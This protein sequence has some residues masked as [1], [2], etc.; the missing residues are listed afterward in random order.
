MIRRVRNADRRALVSTVVLTIVAAVLA[1]VTLTAQGI[2]PQRA[3][4]N[5]GGV[6]VTRADSGTLARFIPLVQQLNSESQPADLPDFDVIQNGK[7]V[8]VLDPQTGSLALVDPRTGGVSAPVALA[9]PVSVALGGA[10]ESPVLAFLLRST[11]ALFVLEPGSLSAFKPEEAQ[12][13]ATVDSEAAVAV[14]DSGLVTVLNPTTRTLVSFAAGSSEG[15][16]AQP[17]PAD[18]VTDG[19]VA[20]AMVGDRPVVLDS[21]GKLWAGGA[22]VD[23]ARE[24]GSQLV[25]QKSGPTASTAIVAGTRGLFEVGLD[26]G[27]VSPLGGSVQAV[28][29]VGAVAAPVRLPGGC[30]YG[31]FV[32]ADYPRQARVCSGGDQVRELRDSQGQFLPSDRV[33]TLTYRVNFGLAVLNDTSNGALWDADADQL[34]QIVWTQDPKE[35]GEPS[36]APTTFVETPA[37]CSTDPTSPQAKDD[38][39]GARAGLPVVIDVLRNDQDADCDVMA[40]KGTPQQ[41]SGPDAKV[42]LVGDGRL[43]QITPPQGAT[44]TLEFTYVVSDPRGD[45]DTGRISV[46]V[47]S[48][49]LPP[50]Q[51]EGATSSTVVVSGKSVSYAVLGDWEDPDG[52]P[53]QLTGAFAPNNEGVVRFQPDGLVT[54][55]DGGDNVG[56]VSLVVIVSDG[57]VDVEG[58]L[59]VDVRSPEDLDPKARPDYATGSVGDIVKID[60]LTN[61]SDP[62]GDALRLVDVKPQF[63]GAQD[64]S[65]DRDAGVLALTATAPGDFGFSYQLAAGRGSATGYARIRIEK[66]AGNRPPAAM[67]DLTGAPLNGDVTVD[68]LRNDVDPD[69]DVLAVT[70]VES[71]DPAV[72]ARIDKGATVRI[73]LLS[74]ITAPVRV[75][76]SVTDGQEQVDSYITVFLNSAGMTQKPLARADE[77]VVRAGSMTTIPVLANDVAGDGGA[78]TLGRDLVTPAALGVAAVN[79]SSVRYVAPTTGGRD[80]FDYRLVAASDPTLRAVGSV[81]VIVLDPGTTNSPPRPQQIEA[82]VVAGK[83]VSIAVPLD[84]IDPEGD[85]VFLDSVTPSALLG[86]IPE[87]DRASQRITYQAGTATGTDRFTYRVCD[88]ATPQ[89]CA[90]GVV[91]VGVYTRASNEA[92]EAGPDTV[93]MRPGKTLAVDVLANDSDPDGDEFGFVKSDPLTLSTSSTVTARLD[94]TGKLLLIEASSG[95]GT[96]SITY[97]IT[98]GRNVSSGLVSVRVS[99]SAPQFAPVAA[100]DAVAAADI[101]ANPSGLS[102]DVLGNDLDPDGTRVDLS[103]ALPEGSTATVT[104]DG[105]SIRVV[106]TSS[107]QSLSYFAV[108][109][110]GLRGMAFVLVPPAGQAP[111]VLVPGASVEIAAGQPVELDIATLVTDPDDGPEPVRLARAQDSVTASAGK[112]EALSP[113]TFRYTAPTMDQSPP[114]KAV[115]SLQVTD[116]TPSADGA[117]VTQI[118]VPVVITAA[119]RPPTIETTTFL[120]EQAVDNPAPIDLGRT[121]TDPDVEDQGGPFTFV[122]GQGSGSGI[123]WSLSADGQLVATV[124]TVSP[125][126]PIGATIKV[127]VSVSDPR[128]LTS[129]EGAVLLRSVASTKPALVAA[130][131]TVERLDQGAT[132][133]VDVLAGN[134][135]PFE[136]EG[137]ELTLTDVVVLDGSVVATAS[138]GTVS[139]SAADTA[140]PGP[141]HVKYTIRDY[142][143]REATAVILVV[144]WGKPTDPTNVQKVESTGSTVTL[145]WTASQANTFTLDPDATTVKYNVTY[146]GRSTPLVVSDPRIVVGDGGLG[147]P[148]LTPGEPYSFTVTAFNDVGESQPATA[149][150]FTPD[151]L[152]PVPE[153]SPETTGDATTFGLDFVKLTFRQPSPQDGASTIQRYDVVYQPAAPSAPQSLRGIAY[154]TTTTV[155]LDGLTAGQRYYIQL[156]PVNKEVLAQGIAAPCGED[157]TGRTPI[158]PPAAP[159]NLKV[160]GISSNPVVGTSITATWDPITG[161]GTGGDSTISYLCQLYDGVGAKV[162]GAT[163]V[164]TATCTFDGLQQGADYRVGV[165]TRNDKADSSEVKSPVVQPIGQPKQVQGV[166]LTATGVSNQVRIT[167]TTPTSIADT[168]GVDPS[169]VTYFYDVNGDSNWRGPITSGVT[170]TSGFSNGTAARVRVIARNGSGADGTPSTASNQVVPFGAL[171]TP[172]ATASASGT[173]ATLGWAAIGDAQAVKQFD[174]VVLRNDVQ[175]ASFTSATAGSRQYDTGDN[176]RWQI[177]VTAVGFDG[178]TRSNT[179]FVVIPAQRRVVVERGPQNGSSWYIVI[180]VFNF[181]GPR[182]LGCQI[183]T[184]DGDH[185]GT[186]QRNIDT[187]ASG[188]GDNLSNIPAGTA[189]LWN[190]GGRADVNCEGTWGSASW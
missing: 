19:S 154:G 106:P 131:L 180:K 141:A 60:L 184:T 176:V 46:T 111:P 63:G 139:V 118:S 179:A 23:L 104:P 8:V 134:Q 80:R 52:D 130:S 174:V 36:K 32:G 100:D 186:W 108:D 20:L 57:T 62:N 74:S 18:L 85:V 1:V 40:L 4:L 39:A 49:N 140:Q 129:Q 3:E 31:A 178:A 76:Y 30:V 156:C 6:W 16:D 17:L 169:K 96:G 29:K 98:D 44:G 75:T 66:P 15:S 101:V 53:L 73:R 168:G 182:L 61:D 94:D 153:I 51:R 69:G 158:G 93:V 128:G 81:T 124:T 177:N 162:G 33:G 188:Y 116:G 82:R 171:S 88:V 145:S 65:I 165:S 14:S 48:G 87:V 143:N 22:V 117:V 27:I 24:A 90:D 67:A 170:T 185:N 54:Y 77:V 50:A 37:T 5:D 35:D 147:G 123:S 97:R 187:D 132:E 58:K 163:E 7:S 190:G 84:G 55:D 86:G 149:G 113:T 126:F 13:V 151:A 10:P 2:P 102:V 99:E 119:N 105:R 172:S 173:V 47:R 59:V 114:A 120:V 78:L 64:W 121:V 95:A 137:R 135:N 183:Y 43:V 159:S 34:K 70:R 125:E 9:S 89:R 42:E 26:D 45:E 56:K 161:A 72:S 150:P 11:G 83:T 107:W 136:A 166:A 21:E 28:D 146:T 144:V 79:G 164:T 152:P 115:L 25:L 167:F 122:P 92:P 175:Y 38:V 68:V 160:T 71:P 133:T 148:P 110:D 155:Q 181:G 142:A 189:W 157:P 103:A 138:G 109:R 112:A 127:P 12:P 91:K 41:V